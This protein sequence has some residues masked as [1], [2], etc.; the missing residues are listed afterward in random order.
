LAQKRLTVDMRAPA[1]LSGSFAV[2]RCGL[3]VLGSHHALLGGA[4]A[5]LLSAITCCGGTDDALIV[6]ESERIGVLVGRRV[7]LCQ[8][9]I[10]SVGRPITRS[11][12]DIAMLRSLVALSG[13]VQTRPGGLLTAAGHALTNDTV[14]IV[15]MRI[16]ITGRQLATADGLITIRRPLI[17]LG[18]GLI[19]V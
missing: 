9:P 7:E 19:A 5:I 12:H 11:G 3:A 18:A 2:L 1:L 4:C 6:G 15:H 10:A 16:G 14:D 13:R 17:S 8:C